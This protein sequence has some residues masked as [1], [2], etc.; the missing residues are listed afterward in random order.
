[1][2]PRIASGL[3]HQNL[4]AIPTPAIPSWIVNRLEYLNLNHVSITKYFTHLAHDAT[5]KAKTIIREADQVAA[6]LNLDDELL[7]RM[8]IDYRSK[9]SVLYGFPERN[10]C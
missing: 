5:A 4:G 9:A 7:D 3:T 1:M 8:V 10:R 2:R 6:A